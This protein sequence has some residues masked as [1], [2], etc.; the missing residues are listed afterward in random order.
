MTITERGEKAAPSSFNHKFLS[1]FL[2]S[3]GLRAK[4]ILNCWQFESREVVIP[5]YNRLNLQ[6][7]SGHCPECLQKYCPPI[8]AFG[9][10]GYCL[11]GPWMVWILGLFTP[12][13]SC[14]AGWCSYALKRGD[15]S[16]YHYLEL[17]IAVQNRVQALD[18]GNRVQIPAGHILRRSIT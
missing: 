2:T 4:A 14:F 13:I 16:I 9:P 7:E 10:Q 8:N 3:L 1:G 6:H 17:H 5:S 15:S 12:I 18:D 11:W